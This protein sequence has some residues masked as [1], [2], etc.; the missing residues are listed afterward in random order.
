MQEY[1]YPVTNNIVT[2]LRNPLSLCLK[3]EDGIC[4]AGKGHYLFYAF[5]VVG[6]EIKKHASS[7]GQ[8]THMAFCKKTNFKCCLTKYWFER[9][10]PVFV[11]SFFSLCHFINNNLGN[12]TR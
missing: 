10:F 11:S 8:D 1:P 9:L 12:T 5:V 4:A 3:W 7:N 2:L 6:V